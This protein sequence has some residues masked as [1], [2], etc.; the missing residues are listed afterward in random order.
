MRYFLEY[1]KPAEKFFERH[2]DIREE[3][4]A[5]LDIF[6]TGV[7]SKEVD[8][9]TIKGKRNEYYRMRIGKWR[10]IFMI[11]DEIITVVS[12]LLTDSR[13]DIYKKMGGLK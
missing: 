6:M 3:Y 12:V 11:T 10:V 2:E 9:K 1:K 5:A 4:E 13:G 7:S 8:E